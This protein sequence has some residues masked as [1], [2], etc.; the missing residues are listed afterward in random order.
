VQ[1]RRRVGHGAQSARD[2]SS[3]PRGARLARKQSSIHG[4]ADGGHRRGKD[5]T[6]RANAPPRLRGDATK[7]IVAAEGERI[8]GRLGTLEACFLDLVQERLVA[9]A[10]NLRRLVPVPSKPLQ[11]VGDGNP[12]GGP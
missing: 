4:T 12:L 3:S 6:A 8:G 1:S 9:D 2:V 7:V 10:E 11:C 5:L